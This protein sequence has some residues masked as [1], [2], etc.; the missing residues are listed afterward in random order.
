MGWQRSMGLCD[1]GLVYA[2]AVQNQASAKK[3][4]CG[5]WCVTAH[6]K[7]EGLEISRVGRGSN[8]AR[9]KFG[10]I[11]HSAAPRRHRR[12]WFKVENQILSKVAHIH[13]AEKFG[14]LFMADHKILHE[15][16]NRAI[17]TSVLC[18]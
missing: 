13:R 12:S 9:Q 14:D 10:F 17:I 1:V 8:G 5:L 16:V 15:E 11:R 18:D 4:C 6:A 2:S 7:P 3:I